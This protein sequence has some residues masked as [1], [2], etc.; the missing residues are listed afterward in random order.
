MEI[1]FGNEDLQ[2]MK[3][4]FEI[5]GKDHEV[6]VTLISCCLILEGDYNIINSMILGFL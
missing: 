4:G 2:V 1:M 6:G 5:K 3:D